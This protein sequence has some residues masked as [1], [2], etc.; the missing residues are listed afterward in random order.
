MGQ[1]RVR[2]LWFEA[3]AN[4]LSFGKQAAHKLFK[5]AEAHVQGRS[6]RAAQNGAERIAQ[7]RN[8]DFTA[9]I[10]RS[11]PPETSHGVTIRIAGLTMSVIETFE[12]RP[13]A[14][15]NE[16]VAVRPTVQRQLLSV[17]MNAQAAA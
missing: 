14:S 3:I 1:L 9:S 11:I 16:P 15:P 4:Q 13:L 8:Q 6:R 5:R 17:R 2:G 12:A 7:A 10:F